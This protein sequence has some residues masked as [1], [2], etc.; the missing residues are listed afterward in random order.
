MAIKPYLAIPDRYFPK[1]PLTDERRRIVSSHVGLAYSFVARYRKSLRQSGR[2]LW[3]T[4]DDMACVAV[5]TVALV[6]A[7]GNYDDNIGTTGTYLYACMKNAFPS[8]SIHVHTK[9]HRNRLIMFTDMATSRDRRATANGHILDLAALAHYRREASRWEPPDMLT[10]MRKNWELVFAYVCY[11]RTLRQ[12]A[13]EHGVTHQRIH[14]KILR[15]LKRIRKGLGLREPVHSNNQMNK[16]KRK[17][18]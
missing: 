18:K 10:Y 9:K 4:R 15:E 11:D 16:R 14:Q 3:G 1:A 5:M 2:K 17:E 12:L 8:L 6:V 13:A 7:K